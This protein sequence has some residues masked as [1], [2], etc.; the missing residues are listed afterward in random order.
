M[1]KDSSTSLTLFTVTIK[2]FH[3]IFGDLAIEG[4]FATSIDI[5]TVLSLKLDHITKVGKFGLY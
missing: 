3:L 4:D 1:L 5:S 2:C